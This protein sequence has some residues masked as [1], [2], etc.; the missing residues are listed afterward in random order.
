MHAMRSQNINMNS[1][2][3]EY[4]IIKPNVM[5]TECYMV[6][7]FTLTGRRCIFKL[8]NNYI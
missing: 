7:N 1:L 4:K 8:Q 5:I 3:M 2:N 6:N